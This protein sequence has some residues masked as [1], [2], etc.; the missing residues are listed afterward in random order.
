MFKTWFLVIFWG[1]HP[2]PL[3]IINF[4]VSSSAL[5]SMKPAEDNMTIRFVSSGS[6]I[7]AQKKINDDKRQL[8]VQLSNLK[9]IRSDNR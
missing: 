8:S 7:P 3:N 4:P 2:N 5:R 1:G 6:F 9:V